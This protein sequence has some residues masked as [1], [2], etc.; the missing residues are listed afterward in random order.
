MSA[1]NE[2][3]GGDHYKKMKIQPVEYILANDIGFIEGSVI[4]YVSRWRNKN[5]LEDLK[6]ARHLLDLF[7]ESKEPSKD[8]DS[9]WIQRQYNNHIFPKIVDSLDA[10]ILEGGEG[11]RLIDGKN[12]ELISKSPIMIYEWI[13]IGHAVGLRKEGLHYELDLNTGTLGVLPF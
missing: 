6:K 10:F 12:V 3:I 1:I 8:S 13:M 5:G 4:K 2:Q 11:Y 9:T 7:I